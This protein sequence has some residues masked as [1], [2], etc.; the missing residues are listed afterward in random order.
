MLI[1]ARNNTS[2]QKQIA[3]HSRAGWDDEVLMIVENDDKK[4][5]F[6]NA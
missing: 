3:E 2:K 1:I 4:H 5:V 6:H